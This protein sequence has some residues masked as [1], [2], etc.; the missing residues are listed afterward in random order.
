MKAYECVLKYYNEKLRTFVKLVNDSYTEFYQNLSIRY[1][2]W[3]KSLNI[4]NFDDLRELF[5]LE[6]YLNRVPLDV[7]TYL[8]ER[9]V[10]TARETAKIS[11][12]YTVIHKMKSK[13]YNN[14]KIQ[15]NRLLHLCKR[16]IR[17]SM[18]SLKINSLDL[19]IKV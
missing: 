14:F 11:N 15:A 13:T 2:R 18:N 4:T 19:L 8:H 12:E 5:L 6:Q 16:L 10:K 17:Q 1:E 7:K 9:N 3:L